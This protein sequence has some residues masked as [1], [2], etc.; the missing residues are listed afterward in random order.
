[1]ADTR[2]LTTECLVHDLNNVFETILEA[3]ELI[4]GDPNWGDLAATILRSVERGQR[5]VTGMYQQ[6]RTLLDVSVLIDNAMQ[7]TRDFLVAAHRP[8]ID[9]VTELES[10]LR[11]NGTIALERVLV[12]LFLNAAQAMPDGGQIDVRSRAV[13]G[14]IEIVVSDNGPGIPQRILRDIFKPHFSTKSARSGLGLHIVATIVKENE[15]TVT[16]G[17]REDSHGAVFTV[18][19]PA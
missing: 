18:R 15:G 1:M 2:D 3:A 9:F 12:N 13:N 7:F 4:A 19:V 10:G 6:S 16:A 5:I 8:N 17:N 11:I 14:H